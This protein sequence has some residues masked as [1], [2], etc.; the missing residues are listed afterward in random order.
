[1]LLGEIVLLVLRECASFRTIGKTIA[2]PGT[3]MLDDFE[4][5]VNVLHFRMDG[6]LRT[7]FAAETASDTDILDDTHFHASELLRSA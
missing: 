5:M 3:F 4:H 1:M 2:A 7:N 6:A